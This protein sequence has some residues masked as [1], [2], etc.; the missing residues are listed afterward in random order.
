EV[1]NA[2]E[3]AVIGCLPI[4]RAKEIQL[5]N[6]L[7][8][9][10]IEN[11]PDRAL[12]FLLVHFACAERIDAH[13]NRLRVPN[14]VRKLNFTSVCQA[15]CDHVLR[16]PASHVSGASVD[17][18]RVFSGKRSPT[19]PSHSAVAIANDLAPGYSC[20]AFRTTDHKSASRIDEVSRFLIEPFRRH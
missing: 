14:G 15:G 17:F 11:V 16:N 12:Q 4:D 10:E 8:R 18:A 7:G 6:D 3:M 1:V 9:L 20:I 13:A 2:P 19:V 5:L